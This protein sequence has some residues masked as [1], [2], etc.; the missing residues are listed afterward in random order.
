LSQPSKFV[1]LITIA[2]MFLNNLIVK[3]IFISLSI[4]SLLISCDFKKETALLPKASGRPGEMIVVMDSAQWEGSLG[5]SVRATFQQEIKG[6][7]RE[8]YLFKINRVDPIKLNGILKSVKNMVF[9]VTM[10]NN[11]QS[12]R[13]LK[14][15]F[16][17]SSVDKIKN[18]PDIFVF[19]AVDEFSRGQN[20]MYLFG[21]NEESL[22]SN[23]DKNKDRLQDYFNTAENKRLHAGLYKAKENTNFSDMLIKE[24]NSSIRI[25]FGYKLVTNQPG[26]IWFREINSESDKDI[27]ITYKDYKSEEDFTKSNIISMRDSVAKNQLF[28]DP[29]LSYTYIKTETEVPYI[30]VVTKQVNFNNKF[31][32]ETRGLWKTNN[33]SMGGPFISYTLVDEELNRLYY[34]EGFLYSPGKSQREFM[35]ELEVILNTFQVSSELKTTK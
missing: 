24:H 15:Y 21:N 25:P 31:A 2:V 10:D 6:L 8:E 20:V 30:P 16:T 32:V 7:P 35:R 22:L 12:S 28:E 14:K 33:I 34:I 18:N 29:D 11:S 3:N 26:F 4:I 17:K 27:F 5:E 23:I 13:V 9:V 1:T 19:T